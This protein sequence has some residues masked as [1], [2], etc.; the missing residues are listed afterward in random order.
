MYFF[1]LLDLLEIEYKSSDPHFVKIIKDYY[2]TCVD[3]GTYIL[4]Y[5]FKQNILDRMCA[6]SVFQN[7]YNN[8]VAKETINGIK[9]KKI[10]T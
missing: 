10:I 6:F 8:N 4:I 5:I 1:F 9:Y 7:N 3:L 2:N